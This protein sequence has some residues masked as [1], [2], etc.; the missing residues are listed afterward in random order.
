MTGSPTAPQAILLSSRAAVG[1]RRGAIL[2]QAPT[3]KLPGG[4]FDRVVGVRRTRRGLLLSLKPALISEAFPAI[5]VNTAVPFSFGPPPSAQAA[6]AASFLS[7][8]D[9]SYSVP[10][11]PGLLEA[12]CGAMV[13]N[14]LNRLAPPP[15]PRPWSSVRK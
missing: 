15:G 1:L 14:M 11:I 13:G 5:D 2:A 8:V 4:L 6:T 12:S 10:V 7:D 9:L 3:A